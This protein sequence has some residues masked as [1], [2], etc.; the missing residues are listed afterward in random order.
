MKKSIVTM[1]SL[2][3]AAVI[4]IVTALLVLI[5]YK[6]VYDNDIKASGE[7]ALSSARALAEAIDPAEFNEIMATLEKT[8]HWYWARDYANRLYEKGEL[9]Y[10]YVISAQYDANVKYFLDAQMD[11]DAFDLG[12]GES[13]GNYDGKM[14]ETINTAMETTTEPY[15]LGGYG[16]LISGFAPIFDG[17]T[18]IGVVGVDINVDSA[19]ASANQFA[20][21]ASLIGVGLALAFSVLFF[22]FTRKSIGRPLN[23]LL[24]VSQ[25]VAMG[26]LK[27]APA[28]QSANEIG[29]VFESFRQMIQA[30]RVQVAALETIADN[31]LTVDITPRC[32]ADTMGMALKKITAFLNS[33][34]HK[35]NENAAQVA[36]GAGQIAMGGQALAQG[37]TEQAASVEELHATINTIADETVES[38]KMSAE[39]ADVAA[40]VQKNAREGIEKMSEMVRTTREI[41]DAGQGIHKVIKVIDDIA[42]QTN[43]LALNAAVEAA[44]AGQHGKGFAVVADEV[45]QLA[46]K[47]A[48]AAKETD[49]LVTNSMQ[50]ATLGVDMAE[51][52]AESLNLIV[53]G[54][55]DNANIVRNIAQQ[56]EKQ[57]EHMNSLNHHIGEVSE[58][59]QQNSAT[60]EES[61]AASEELKRLAA[62]LED[63]LQHF[64]LRPNRQ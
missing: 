14:F 17:S 26:D 61:S 1:L 55:E 62:A 46:A 19:L 37:A 29:R 20:L 7:L 16:A 63:L 32:E 21:F 45:R 9:T 8:E 25:K 27:T 12:E 24:D 35:L 60:A 30:T 10:C 23:E 64:K 53:S 31:D 44:R 28:Y 39:A 11:E 54:I 43:I 2:A 22:V 59:V 15:D 48:E 18:V 47:S 51:N 56:L 36:S 4:L 33:V 13:A 41:S 40:Q 52:T 49:A 6:N 42:F 38:V 58:V 57:S 3:A 5:S 50:K 34:F